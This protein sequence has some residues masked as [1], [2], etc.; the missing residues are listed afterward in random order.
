MRW[1][2]S[3]NPPDQ[4][5]ADEIRG[6]N[7]P[8]TWDGPQN[9]TP[10]APDSRQIN[11][12]SSRTHTPPKPPQHAPQ[13]HT[14]SSPPF[15]GSSTKPAG[16]RQATLVKEDSLCAFVK[17]LM[18]PRLSLLNC[19]HCEC[20]TSFCSRGLG[21]AILCCVAFNYCR[22]QTTAD[23]RGEICQIKCNKNFMALISVLHFSS[24]NK[25]SCMRLCKPR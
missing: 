2:S 6:N 23:K 11:R 24:V 16:I 25:A 17:F 14:H 10:L 20:L 15:C 18:P 21:N 8:G 7:P 4:R 19:G 3:S 1:E 9:A 22:Y 13:T 12:A 5:R